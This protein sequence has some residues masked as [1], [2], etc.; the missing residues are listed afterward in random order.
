MAM[1]TPTASVDPSVRAAP[2][3]RPTDRAP[4]RQRARDRDDDRF[5]LPRHLRVAG[6]AY[7]LVTIPLAAALAW[8][9]A[10]MEGFIT[11][12]AVIATAY[13]LPGLAV[14][15]VV[16]R[17]VVS[18]RSP[19]QLWAGGF[20]V[21]VVSAWLIQQAVVRE[22]TA[23]EPLV[24]AS[25]GVAIL[26]IGAANTLVIRSR[27][28]QRAIV[29]DAADSLM[30]SLAFVVPAALVVGDEIV[31]SEDAWFVGTMALVVVGACHGVFVA[32]TVAAQVS[33]G[34]RLSANLGLALMV[35]VL[36]DAVGGVAQG[37]EGF[38]LPTGPLAALHATC[39]GLA[40]LFFLW[41]ERRPPPGLDRFPPQAQVRRRSS[42]TVLVLVAVPVIAA[43][44]WWL[45]DAWVTPAAVG[46]ALA[47]LVLS[48][49]RHLASA[50]ETIRLY[51]AVERAAEERGELL[52]DVMGH[53]DADRHRVA[54][55]LHR[56]AVALYTA[57]VS[58]AASLDRLEGPGKP[59]GPGLGAGTGVGAG[60][61]TG[62]GRG[63]TGATAVGIAA[64]RMRA[65]LARQVDELR[66]LAVAVEPLP[67]AGGGANRLAA[68]VRAYVENL[69]GD[70]ARPELTVEV[71][72]DLSLDWTTEA[73]VLRIVQEATHNAWRHAQATRLSVS[74]VSSAHRLAIE[75]ADDGVG[76]DGIE[77][78]RGIES[79]RTVAG[80]I[81]G[82]LTIV[83]AP[84]QGTTVRAVVE[85]APPTPSRRATL[86]LV[87]RT[88]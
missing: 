21:V 45:D 87:D 6:T 39:L 3:R 19:W 29:I 18:V 52:A 62:T 82:D 43:E 71:S 5:V 70:Q 1:G 66:Q 34:D 83:G 40:V 67:R 17:N 50:R 8:P 26:L 7:V 63:P 35:A 88:D 54:A 55:H 12:L 60:R 22:W 58:F 32:T 15:A 69:Y 64:E 48:S 47:L 78:G 80:F 84:G 27:S 30:A 73:I 74:I 4:A 53:V 72:P 49:L 9:A 81:D 38:T 44:A 65:D 25:V 10:G 33:P 42:V 14:A 59:A 57:M 11:A 31:G 2:S 79:M 16:Q 76:I 20:A 77:P 56:Q 75:V 61:G 86:R 23:L 51:G 41:S 85:V 28:G 13:G 24:P 68:L 36:A 37:L 46:A